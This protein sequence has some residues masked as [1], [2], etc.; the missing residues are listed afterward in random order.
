MLF[1]QAMT[2]FVLFI[3]LFGIP[4]A[5]RQP[6][7]RSF[8][9]ISEQLL[10]ERSDVVE[11]PWEAP[12]EY[13]VIN[14]W[15]GRMHQLRPGQKAKDAAPDIPPTSAA[16]A[17]DKI[18]IDKGVDVQLLL[19][20]RDL[21]Y[22]LI[23]DKLKEDWIIYMTSKE[24]IAETRPD[25]AKK[26][27][28][29]TRDGYDLNL[30]GAY[31]ENIR[32]LGNQVKKSRFTEEYRAPNGIPSECFLML[33]S[34]LEFKVWV[35]DSM[36]QWNYEEKEARTTPSTKRMRISQHSSKSSGLEQKQEPSLSKKIPGQRYLQWQHGT[37][38][39]LL[40]VPLPKK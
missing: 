39:Y 40:R 17:V 33:G 21:V 9:R 28:N 30:V 3:T 24:I 35:T 12:S 8:D 6:E 37:R 1:V 38:M 2:R 18:K 32:E 7:K 19:E 16:D 20:D 23:A 13:V 36:V 5:R 10:N 11:V 4:F 22:E 31:L 14:K 15:Y 29:Q 34:A 27:I 25:L 26:L